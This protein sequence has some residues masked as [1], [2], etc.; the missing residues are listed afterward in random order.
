MCDILVAREDTKFGLPEIKLGLIPGMG[1][2]QRLTKIAGKSRAARHIFT[3]DFFNAEQALAW[4]IVSDVFK[5][6]NYHQE[7]LKLA[8]KVANQS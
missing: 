3:G 5:K 8:E 1:G 7:V 6:E 4:G 2:T